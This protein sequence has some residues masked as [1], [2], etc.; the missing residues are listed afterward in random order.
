M[1]KKAML[2]ECLWCPCYYGRQL[3][4]LTCIYFRFSRFVDTHRDFSENDISTLPEE[5]F[6]GLVYLTEL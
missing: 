5:T 4:K 2:A 6:H 3:P 1:V